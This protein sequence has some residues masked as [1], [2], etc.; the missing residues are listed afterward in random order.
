M[1]DSPYQLVNAGFLNHQQYHYPE[2]VQF[3]CW[4]SELI[5]RVAMDQ[6]AHKDM[7]QVG[8]PDGELEFFT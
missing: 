7:V 6:A 1:V 2:A 4:T 5:S 3:P 8:K